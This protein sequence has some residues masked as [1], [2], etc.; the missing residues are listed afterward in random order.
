MEGRLDMLML[1]DAMGVAAGAGVR[2]LPLLLL[3]LLL[4]WVG[5]SLDRRVSV[6]AL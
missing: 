5:S 3:V 1:G 2:V 4:V 6:V